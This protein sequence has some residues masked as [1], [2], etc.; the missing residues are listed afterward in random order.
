MP[1]VPQRRTYLVDR[2][3]QLKYIL[4]LMGWGVVL[5]ALFG[6]WTHQ[7]HLQA[8]EAIVRDPGQRVLVERA[9]RQLLWV[10]A[11]IGVLCVTAL[12]LLGFIMTHRVAGPVYVIGHHLAVLGAGRYPTRRALRKHDEL[13]ALN[14]RLIEAVEQLRER[15]ARRLGH[16]EAAVAQMKAAAGRAPDLRPVLA[17]LEDE[18]RERRAALDESASMTPAPSP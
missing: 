8:V 16:L 13:K 11:G 2:A 9:D 1:H 6:L 5:A 15:D 14:A 17:P 12:G 3:F 18:I 7:A 10:L 4:L